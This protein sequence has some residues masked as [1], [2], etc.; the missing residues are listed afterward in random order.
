[1][2]NTTLLQIPELPAGAKSP[3]VIENEKTRRFEVYMTGAV[4]AKDQNA[5]AGGESNGDAYLI[6][7]TP[8]GA[9]ATFTAGNMAA[10]I[11]GAWVEL[12]VPANF[13]RR[14]YSIA[15]SAFYIRVS[16]AWVAAPTGDFAVQDDSVEILASAAVLNFTGSGVVVTDGGGG[17]ANVAIS[18]SAVSSVNGATGTVVLDADDIGVGATYEVPTIAD[19]TK[20]D[21]IEAGADV[22]DEAN[23]TAALDG[24][25]LTE[26][27]T[28][29]SG[30]QF[31]MLDS[32]ASGELKWVDSDNL[33][34]GGGGGSLAIAEDGTSKLAAATTLNFIGPTVTDAGGG[35]ADI[36][37]VP[38]S[39]ARAKLTSAKTAQN[40]T[41][42]TAISWDQADFQDDTWWAGG[43]PTRLTAPTGITRGV[44]HA[45]IKISSATAG[46]WI[47]VTIRKN[48][49]TIV[50]GGRTEVGATVAKVAVS[51]GEISFSATDY[52]EVLV[53]TESDTS[54]DLDIESGF[55]VSSG[56]VG[57]RSVSTN[58]LISEFTADD[59]QT[60]YVFDVSNY[61]AVNITLYGVDLSAADL[62]EV[63][64]SIDN[65]STYKTTTGDYRR[66][67]VNS[68]SNNDAS[69]SAFGS[70]FSTAGAQYADMEFRNLNVGRA[71]SRSM[72]GAD[73]A[74][75]QVRDAIA[76]FSG[77]ITH[78]KLGSAGGSATLGGGHISVTGTPKEI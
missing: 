31:L 56:G 16:G 70:T 4:L 27:A 63:W 73:G 1:M 38:A 17:V 23:V 39:G 36:T 30:D 20:L 7:A 5:P 45:Y 69:T 3:E 18:A 8:S 49:T 58:Q 11:N 35:Q 57:A 44:F 74:S 25:T 68:L 12:A 24:A 43:N 66:I 76:N 40:Y 33:P 51:T 48:G 77:P 19:L 71:F 21:G 62:I 6:G 65:G 15:D 14:I 67:T 64:A 52:F 72:T 54:V 37:I 13:Y 28:P 60:N 78:L 47:E 55:S 26:K 34:G 10:R 59:T 46:E 2:T 9:F 50:G 42:A 32:A 75:A 61:S 41:T 29:V 53:Q 22:T